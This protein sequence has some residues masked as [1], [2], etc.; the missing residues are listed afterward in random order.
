MRTAPDL[1]QVISLSTGARLEP[2]SWAPQEPSGVH[3]PLPASESCHP[4]SYPCH[5]LQKAFL[6]VQHL[7]E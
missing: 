4:K 6:C 1:S 5:L 3:S 7:L 2:G